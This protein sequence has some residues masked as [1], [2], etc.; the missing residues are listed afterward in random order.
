[1]PLITQI[2]RRGGK[3]GQSCLLR[4][5]YSQI[6]WF[7]PCTF[8]WKHKHLFKLEL[9]P[10]GR[11]RVPAPVQTHTQRDRQTHAHTRANGWWWRYWETPDTQYWIGL[12]THT[13]WLS[14]WSAEIVFVFFLAHPQMRLF[15]FSHLHWILSCKRWN[16]SSVD[17]TKD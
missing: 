12:E 1:M 3:S 17:E 14:A 15:I 10:L 9:D 7:K 6:Q 8:L 4:E 16:A 2:E 11:D 5:D 13:I